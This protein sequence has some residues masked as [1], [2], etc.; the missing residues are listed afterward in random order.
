MNSV[1]EGWKQV[2]NRGGGR[3]EEKN[4]TVKSKLK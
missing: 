1:K 3:R 2:L 4:V